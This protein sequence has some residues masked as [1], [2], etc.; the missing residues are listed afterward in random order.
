M[1]FVQFIRMATGGAAMSKEKELVHTDVYDM[2]Y[3]FVLCST[4]QDR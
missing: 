4:T 1:W 3:Y 2:K